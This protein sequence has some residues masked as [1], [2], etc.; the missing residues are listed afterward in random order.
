M[1]AL[2]LQSLQLALREL[3]VQLAQAKTAEK[4][5]ALATFKEQ[6]AQYG[7]TQQEV[8]SALGYIQ[9]KP[10]R[11]PAKYYDPSS[12]RSWSGRGPRPKWLEGKDLN[13]YAVDR[14]PQPWWPGD[15]A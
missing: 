11:A 14:V 12:G 10:K 15:D 1:E 13:D 4:K 6:V 8:L 3:D 9:A 2:T 5:A 7:I